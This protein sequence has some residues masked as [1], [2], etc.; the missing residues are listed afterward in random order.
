MTATTVHDAGTE[1]RSGLGRPS[2]IIA[3][4]CGHLLLF[5]I[6]M[7]V[8]PF[9]WL[10]DAARFRQIAATP[11]TPY[12]EQAI[13]YM[14]LEL[15]T[16]L[17]IGTRSLSTTTFMVGSVAL[18]GDVS[19][20]LGVAYGWG[21][22]TAAAYLAIA[23]P[24]LPFLYFR[25]DLAIVALAAWGMALAV[26]NHRALGGSALGLS[27]MGKLWP[28]V[29]VPTLVFRRP[30]AV[31]WALTVVIVGT[32]IWFSV[33]GPGAFRQVLTFRSAE[34]WSVGSVTGSAIWVVTGETPRFE[35]GAMRV[36][37]VRPWE[38]TLG[39]AVLVV[40]LLLT[41][42]SARNDAW[43][44]GGGPAL[45]SV[46]SLLVCSPLFSLQYVAW[47]LPWTAVCAT[48]VR[49]PERRLAGLA[50]VA[51]ALSG[52]ESVAIGSGIA[53]YPADFARNVVCLCIPI[54]WILWSLRPDDVA[55]SKPRVLDR[56]VD[57]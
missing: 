12:R 16:V 50:V 46:T 54:A 20:F 6:G 33:S 35:A 32:A 25:F 17:A 41:Y 26:R 43:E 27:V 57:R 49:G 13:E 7:K 42:R 11:L 2:V 4:A 55:D 31:A 14:P 29:L 18:A 19:T 22:R 10:D 40:L 1:H 44:L 5:A 28:I 15:L 52:I 21:R 34:G 37:S 24:V 30:R 39:L 45:A 48:S 3:L 9:H 51:I 36:G 23:L 53:S 56:I 8:T 47:L 38:A